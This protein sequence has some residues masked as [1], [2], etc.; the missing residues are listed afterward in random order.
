MLIAHSISFKFNA[1]KGLETLQRAK[2]CHRDL[3]P[4]N[5]IILDDKC[6]VIDF[7]M[8]LRIPYSPAGRHLI[9][10]HIPCGKLVSKSFPLDQL[11]GHFMSIMQL[12]ANNALNSAT[13][14]SRN[15]P[16]ATV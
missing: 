13:Y 6:L 7:G 14:V 8:S 4:E 16:K 1:Q 11:L 5:L 2:I 12:L 10:A 3:S 9:K 15:L